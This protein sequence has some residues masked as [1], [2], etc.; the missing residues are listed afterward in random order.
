M[1]PLIIVRRFPYEE[2]Y[3]THLEFAVSNGT[4]GG[5]TD[6]YCGVHELKEIGDALQKFPAKIG[7][8]YRYEYGSE[9]PENPFYRYFVLRVYTIDSVGHCAIQFIINLNTDEPN[10]GI[11]RFSISVEAASINRLGKLFEEFSKLEHLEFRW[12]LKETELFEEYQLSDVPSTVASPGRIPRYFPATPLG[13][14]KTHSGWDPIAHA[15]KMRK[16]TWDVSAFFLIDSLN[17]FSKCT[18]WLSL[19][20]PYNMPDMEHSQYFNDVREI[21]ESSRE[22]MNFDYD[23]ELF[24]ENRE[25]PAKLRCHFVDKRK[26]EIELWLPGVIANEVADKFKDGREGFFCAFMP[27][28]F[29]D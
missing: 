27:P 3:H 13:N 21:Y 19:L 17:A 29:Y 15:E 20:K 4:F 2:P 12:S 22:V 16:S 11:C 8:E 6:I 24:W 10:E 5:N 25:F 28:A 26:Y 14:P 1:E 18:Q 9:N 23:F 7:D